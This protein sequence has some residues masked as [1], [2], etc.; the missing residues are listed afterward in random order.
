MRFHHRVEWLCAQF[1]PSFT[2][3]S[4]K[5]LPLRLWFKVLP[6]D[7]Y[8]G[9]MKVLYLITTTLHPFFIVYISVPYNAVVCFAIGI[10]WQTKCGMDE[11]IRSISNL[12]IVRGKD[13]SQA[14]VS[15]FRDPRLYSS[16]LP[17]DNAFTCWSHARPFIHYEKSAALLSNSQSIVPS[18]DRVVERGWK[19]FASR[20]YVHQY[21][22][23]GLEEDDFVDCF[24][25]L[26]QVLA[27]YGQLWHSSK[28]SLCSFPYLTFTNVYGVAKTCIYW[29]RVLL[30]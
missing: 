21:Q 3:S 6:S 22:R 20:A 14:D 2:M 25:G 28:P 27:S 29:Q 7:S 16:W 26:E 17:T 8:S 5:P 10:N 13:V 15:A 9:S 23:H 12:L 24:A 1:Q 30:C 11:A 4:F 18:L 19:M